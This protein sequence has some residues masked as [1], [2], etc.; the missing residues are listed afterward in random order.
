[1]IK[2]TILGEAVGKQ[3]PRVTRYGAYTPAKTVKWEQSVAMQALPHKPRELFDCALH[4]ELIFII[5]RPK[6]APKKRLYP[7]TKPDLDNL[8][9]AILDALEGIIYTNDS[10]IVRKNLEKVYGSPPR[11]EICIKKMEECDG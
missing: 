7:E 5:T 6:S 3:R 11:V 2:F 4:V 1:M 10:R 8:T 9:K